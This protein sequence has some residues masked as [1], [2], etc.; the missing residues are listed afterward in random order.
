MLTRTL[1]I[2]AT[3]LLVVFA[4]RKLYNRDKPVTIFWVIGAIAL[5]FGVGMI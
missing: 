5:N 2:I 3:W 1:L 4:W